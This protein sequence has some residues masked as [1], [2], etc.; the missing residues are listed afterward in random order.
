MLSAADLRS[1]RKAPNFCEKGFH[2]EKKIS[3]ELQS[4]KLNQ[5]MT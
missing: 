1:M 4:K 5:L 2:K 3:P